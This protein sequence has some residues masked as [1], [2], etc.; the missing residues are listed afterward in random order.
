LSEL[1]DVFD[2]F[3]S[4]VHRG[5]T[6]DATRKKLIGL[7]IDEALVRKAQARFEEQTGRIRELRDPPG[8]IDPAGISPPWYAGPT[9]EHRHALRCRRVA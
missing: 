6:P 4:E 2:L 8:L 3:V 9:P 1:D 7:R 5:R